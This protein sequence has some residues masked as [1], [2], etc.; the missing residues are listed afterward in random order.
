[1]EWEWERQAAGPF[2]LHQIER[3]TTHFSVRANFQSSFMYY[4][5]PRQSSPIRVID[6]VALATAEYRLGICRGRTIQEFGL[7][8]TSIDSFFFN[9]RKAELAD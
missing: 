4:R 7:N 9:L 8:T 6:L 5:R 2:F 1:M 3:C